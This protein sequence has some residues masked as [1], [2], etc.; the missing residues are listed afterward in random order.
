MIRESMPLS[1]ADEMLAKEVWAVVGVSADSSKFGYKVY[2][3]LKKAGYIVYGINP[4]LEELNGEKIYHDLAS[5]PQQP[6]VVNFV[7][8]PEVTAELVPECAVRGI[9]YLWLQ[10]GSESTE[11]LALARK[12]E[13]TV[14]RGCV[15][16]ELRKRL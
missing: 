13:L 5:L 4:G 15:L 14:L 12:F 8:P 11:T 3:R 9:R 1:G 7:V 10:P 16:R 2:R 6:E